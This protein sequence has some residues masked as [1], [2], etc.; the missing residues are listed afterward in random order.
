MARYVQ[1]EI[2]SGRFPPGHRLPTERELSE[3]FGASRG[4]VRRVLGHFKSLGAITQV[5]GSGTFVSERAAEL[6]PEPRSSASTAVS[7]SAGSMVKQVSPAQLM[8]A[9][10]LIEPQMVA[11]I[12]RFATAADFARMDECLEHSESADSIEAFEHWDGALHQAFAEATHNSFFLRILELTNMVREEGEW[13]RL[14]RISLTSERRR[15]YETQ[16]RAIVAALR[17]RDEEV[18]RSLLE[19]HLLEVKQNLFGR[20]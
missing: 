6:L 8:D 13:G 16:H 20:G 14:K 9:R 11:L 18:A 7:T 10:V 12:V 15:R 19:E 17:D 5:V 2:A 1:G 4:A 3:R